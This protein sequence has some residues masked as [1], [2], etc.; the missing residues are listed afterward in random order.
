MSSVTDNIKSLTAHTQSYVES[1]ISYHKLDLFRKAM[2][3]TIT[4]VRMFIIG[5]L[6]L[7]ALLFF[8]VA[9]AIAIGGWEGFVYV[10]GFYFI[11]FIFT[12]IFIKPIL[13]KK[14]LRASSTLWFNDNED[15]DDEYKRANY[16]SIQ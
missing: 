13:T 11:L 10:G 1:T 4:S 12:A 3:G 7:I 5:L 15:I 6:G 8:S 14:I 9:V 2:R 16:E